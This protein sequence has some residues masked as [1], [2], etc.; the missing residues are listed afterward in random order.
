MCLHATLSLAWEPES[1]EADVPEA[2]E[3]PRTGGR[4]GNSVAASEKANCC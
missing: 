4:S 1:C 2:I 3:S